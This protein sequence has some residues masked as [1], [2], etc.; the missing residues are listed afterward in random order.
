[1][2]YVSLHVETTGINFDGPEVSSGHDIV[3]MGMV[4][5]DSQ[6]N[7][8][9]EDIFYN[10]DAD[11]SASEQYHGISNKFLTKYGVN[12]EELFNQMIGFLSTHMDLYYPI[13]IIGHNAA[14]FTIPFL[15]DLMARQEANL[16]ISTNVID[17]FSVLVVATGRDFTLQ[18]ILGA[19]PSDE[20]FLGKTELSAL[21]KARTYV[22]I[23][24]TLQEG[25]NSG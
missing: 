12:E 16:R 6:F 17:T 19:F 23:C 1:M 9:G 10:S 5:C 21:K 11:A 8:L 13:K 2:I 15:K 14:S 22:N 20:E 24:K 3:S 4:V 7:I 25:Y 18:D